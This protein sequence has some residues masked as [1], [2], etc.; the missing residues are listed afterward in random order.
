MSRGEARARPE[1]AQSRALDRCV[2]RSHHAVSQCLWGLVA[3][4]IRTQ[5]A[6]LLAQLPQPSPAYKRRVWL[7]VTGLALFL[8]LYFL[9]A[10]WFLFTAYRL[11]VAADSPAFSGILVGIC[12]L[13]LAV[14]M[15]KPVF[16]VK[17]GS[18]DDA[19]EITAQQQPRLFAFL[20]ELADGAA[21]PRPHR[22]FLSARVNAAVFYDLSLINL[23]FPSRKNL[24]IGLALVNALTLGEFRAV[25]AHEFGHFTQRSMA[26]MRW[27]YIAQQISAHLVARRDKLDAMLRTLCHIDF[28]VAW[29]GWLLSLIVWSIRSL[30]DS[31]FGAMVILQRALSREMEMQAD[32]VAVALT[33]SDALVHAL[34]RLQAADDA[35]DRTLAFLSH[36]HGR[37]RIPRDVFALHSRVTERMGDILGDPGYGR[38]APVP[39]QRPAEHRVFKPDLAQ[40]PRMWLT[41]PLNHEREA[42]AKRRYVAAPIDDSSPWALFDDPAA[43]RERV[44]AVLQQ[45]QG[46]ET[47]PT[48]AALAD[49]SES[50]DREHL[51]SRYHGVYLGRSAVRGATRPEDLVDPAPAGW[52]QQLDELYPESLLDE[53]ARSRGLENEIVQLRAIES[54]AF[55]PSEGVIRHRGRSIT[56]AELPRVIQTVQAE[57]RAV[58]ERLHAGDRT[59]RAVHLAA[60]AELGGGWDAYLRGLLAVLHYA[61]HTAANLEDLYG[62]FA[63]TLRLVTATRRV[64]SGGMQRLLDSAN[65]LQAPLSAVFRMSPLVT[66]DSSLTGRL[67][68]ASWTES[69]GTEALP[70]ADRDNIG[71]WL[72]VIDS[73]VTKAGSACS[74]LRNATLEQLLLTEAALAEHVRLGTSPGPAA[75]PSVVLATYDVLPPGAERKPPAGLDWWERFQVAQGTVPALARAAVAAGIVAVVLGFGTSVGTATITIYDGLALPVVVNVGDHRLSLRARSWAALEVDG[76]VG[77]RIMARTREGRVVDSFDVARPGS[78]ASF[79]YNVGGATPLVEWTAVYGNVSRPPDRP[80]GA[81]RWTRSSAD[82]LFEKPPESIRTSDKGGVRLVLSGMADALPGVQLGVLASDSDSVR[83]IRAH[84]QWDATTSAQGLSWLTIGKARLPDYR[85]IFAKRLAE[86]PSD[87]VLLRLEQDDADSAEKVLVCSR[88]QARSDAARD[89]ADLKYVA[90]RCISDER[91]M[92]QAFRDGH[93]RWPQHG[94][95]AY[96]AGYGYAAAD[97]WQQAGVALEAAAAALPPVADF[98]SVDL[99][100][101]RRLTTPD[102]GALVAHLAKGSDHLR[103]LVALE[104]GTGI[105][106]GP[107]LAYAEL[108]RGHLDQAVSLAHANPAVEARVLRLAAASDG[109]SPELVRRALALDPGV[110]LDD[111]TRWASIALATRS[112]RDVT[113]LLDSHPAR[114]EYPQRVLSFIRLVRRGANRSAAEQQLNGLPLT[115]RGEAY[116]AG[117]IILGDRAPAAWRHAAKQ[118]LFAPERPYFR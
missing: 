57:A 85:Q 52:R 51:K 81:P 43:L 117:V 6:M 46:K 30:V 114:P 61:D 86:A 60:A 1:P 48:D 12:A 10:A 109:A 65:A 70:P 96:G 24:E 11:T 38:V 76:R 67:A 13:F 110:G 36:E 3:M 84:A 4:P 79:I 22:V 89:D 101:I 58:E 35:W 37:N 59:R 41:H 73:W 63:R 82:V 42:N 34:H 94:W 78:F 108:A 28:R 102:A 115:A 50:F 105:D 31:A 80:L 56:R 92:M 64:S 118:L 27:A 104:S 25:L 26:V 100:R 68:I 54:G 29:V 17:H 112:G 16:F 49:L 23:V 93:G 20:Y 47:V 55:T 19:V 18:V 32:L 77:Y 95:F 75:A 40:P 88:H 97:Q 39:P 2:P 98:V 107:L 33:G 62:V 99:A 5:P 66:L 69:L 83:V 103:Y 74:A 111:A 7:A 9:L 8:A 21:A 71:E 44:S 45:A 14:F 113:P 91:A 87:V 72:K 53:V 106:S 116:C 90:A 15:L